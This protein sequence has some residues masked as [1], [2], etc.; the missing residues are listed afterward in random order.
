[1]A[2]TPNEVMLHYCVLSYPKNAENVDF[3][4][5]PLTF[6]ED[7]QRPAADL[8]IGPYRVQ[9]PLDWSIIIAD[10]DFG[11]I[12]VLD[13]QRLNDRAFTAFAF[14]PIQGFMP[15]FFE[16][17]MLDIY[18]DVSWNVPTLEPGHILAIPLVDGPNPSCIFCLKETTRIPESLDIT[19][20][21]N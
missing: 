21:F 8:Q 2:L 4:F 13:L 16:I 11:Y 14:N 17:T 15:D 7:F 18:P 20:I 10:K 19:R 3:F 1:M 6:R 12:E 5:T 9:L